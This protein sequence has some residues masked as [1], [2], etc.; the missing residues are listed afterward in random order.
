MN[1][2][3]V[4]QGGLHLSFMI[5]NYIHVNIFSGII[6]RLKFDI[7]PKFE[8]ILF[9]YQYH[10]SRR[11]IYVPPWTTCTSIKFWRNYIQWCHCTWF[12]P[13]RCCTR[14]QL[15]TGS[16]S[17]ALMIQ[18]QITSSKRTMEWPTSIRSGGCHSCN[19]YKLYPEVYSTK[20][21]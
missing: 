21:Q 11:I 15:K 17:V 16:K 14:H 10:T 1:L 13:F 3:F 7:I 20:Q 12:F 5:N 6:L 8:R 4:L 18:I 2:S 19:L 9:L